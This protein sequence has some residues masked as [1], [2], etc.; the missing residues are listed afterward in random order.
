LG[1]IVVGEIVVGLFAS[2]PNEMM[3]TGGVAVAGFI[4][5]FIPAKK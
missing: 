3:V 5:S 4:A 2:F 1:F